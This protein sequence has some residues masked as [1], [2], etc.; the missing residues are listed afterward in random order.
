MA[1]FNVLDALNKN[2]KQGIDESPK[3]R[4]R[5]KDISIH[6]M[7]RNE[8]NF[9]E[10]RDIEELAT[11]ILMAGL[12]ENIS[13]TYDPC[14]LGE[15]RIIAGERRWRALLLLVEKGYKEFEFATCQIRTPTNKQ[16]E[17]VEL[18]IANSYRDKTINDMLEEERKLKENLE[19]MKENNITMKG[20]DLSKGRLR[21]IIA[22]ML[23]LSRTKVAQIEN[24]NN[25]LIQ[26]FKEELKNERLTFSTANEL[27]GMTEEK[28]LQAFDSYGHSGNIS[29]N[30][31]KQMK[32][33]D[34]E[35]NND[36]EDAE[37]LHEEEEHEE[38]QMDINNDFPEFVPD[39]IKSD[40]KTNTSTDYKE[41]ESANYFNYEKEAVEQR[42]EQTHYLKLA[43][44]YYDDVLNCK[45]PFEL[46]K[47]DRD[48]RVNDILILQEY[49]EGEMTGRSIEATVTYVLED[50]KGIEEGYCILGILVLAYED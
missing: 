40:S 45:K 22:D 12:M 10:I 37:K 38:G 24:I 14:D 29:M 23:K 28:Q 2:S 17:E 33:A 25:N 9:Y 44:V 20:Y 7:Y 39:S 8:S 36:I 18:I 21:D 30:D 11:K 50:Y 4:F 35:E 3:A 13:V 6:K 1:G 16:E 19:Y 31:V 34:Q 48:F 27:S 43:A 41:G 42:K 5:T 46:R 15:Y 49:K 32:A 47:N 26:E